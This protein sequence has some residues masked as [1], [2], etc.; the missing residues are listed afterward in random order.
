MPPLTTKSPALVFSDS[1]LLHLYWITQI[2]VQRWTS[3]LGA[4]WCLG[5][6]VPVCEKREGVI[7]HLC[8]A[9]GFIGLMTSL[10]GDLLRVPSKARPV[11][12]PCLLGGDIRTGLPNTLCPGAL[13]GYTPPSLPSSLSLPFSFLLQA[14]GDTFCASCS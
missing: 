5:S 2:L 9:S 1:L 10:Q 3:R 6:A 4:F 8:T 13:Q 12:I 14:P 7:V 11:A